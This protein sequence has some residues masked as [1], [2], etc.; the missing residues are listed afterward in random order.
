M[1]EN[2]ELVKG[3]QT[4]EGIAQYDYLSLANIPSDIVKYS[5]QELNSN[6]QKQTRE[7]IG[8]SFY[9]T[10]NEATPS[11]IFQ[12][13]KD[14]QNIVF[15]YIDPNFDL[16]YFTNFIEV[17]SLKTIVASSVQSYNEEV[18]YF[19]LIGD[20]SSDRWHFI[21]APLS[22][23][24]ETIYATVT[25][26]ENGDYQIDKSFSELMEAYTNKINIVCLIHVDDMEMSIPLIG[27]SDEEGTPILL[28]YLALPFNY[29][30][31][32]TCCPL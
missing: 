18:M 20:L 15:K 12:A 31:I 32:Y 24:K 3:F 27:Y 19:S 23:S 7:N 5:K 9:G 21:H 13:L 29:I 6:Q 22:N 10:S 11:Q 8:A 17:D 16:I 26:N 14:G 2:I 1:S 25:L 30:Y 4:Q 28:F